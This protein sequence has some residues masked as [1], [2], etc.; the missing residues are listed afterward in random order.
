M[1]SQTDEE[2]TGKRSTCKPPPAVLPAPYQKN[3]KLIRNRLDEVHRR[4]P[5]AYQ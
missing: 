1:Y 2:E 3:D 5:M 4:P